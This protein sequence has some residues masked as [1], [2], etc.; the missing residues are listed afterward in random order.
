[1]PM[2]WIEISLPQVFNGLLISNR[3]NVAI[4]VTEHEEVSTAIIHSFA[5]SMESND[6]TES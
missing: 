1:M 2:I 5:D 3:L 6:E 4:N